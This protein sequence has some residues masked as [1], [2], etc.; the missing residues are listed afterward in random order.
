VGQQLAGDQLP[1]IASAA[2]EGR[3]ALLL[4]AAEQRVAGTMDLSSGEVVLHEDRDPATEDVLDELILAVIRHGGEVVVV[5][6]ERV[7][8]TD[9]GVAAVYRY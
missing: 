8:P 6:P 3:V 7:M 1:A 4:V 9:S 5:P 2:V